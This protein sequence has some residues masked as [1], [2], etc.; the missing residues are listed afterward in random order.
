MTAYLDKM[1]K[2]LL[3]FCS[4]STKPSQQLVTKVVVA[5]TETWLTSNDHS[6][7][8]QLC[9]NGYRFLDKPREHGRGGGTA[10]LFN[11]SLKVSFSQS[12]HTESLEY[13]EWVVSSCAGHDLRMVIM[14]RQPYSEN[15]RYP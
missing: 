5:I 2:L 10:I 12:G 1:N 8:A 7:R 15:H 11:D 4:W 3:K 14:Y 9:P 6:L 13:S